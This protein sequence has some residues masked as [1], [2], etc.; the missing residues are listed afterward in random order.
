VKRRSIVLMLAISFGFLVCI[1]LGLGWLGLSR[2]SRIHSDLEDLVTKRWAKVK[3]CR[4]ALA[5]S[6]LNSRITVEVFLLDNSDQIAPLLKNRAENT[7]IISAL[8]SQ[9]QAQGV[10]PGREHELLD[11]IVLARTPYIASYLQAL[12]LLIDE[13]KYVKA[14]AVMVD[15]T[16]PLLIRYHEAWNRFVE[17]QGEQMDEAATDS[18]SH[19]A[20]AH[21]VVLSLILLAAALCGAIGFYVTLLMTKEIVRREKAE[22][23][24]GSLNTELEQKVIRRT[25][26]LSL[27]N[28]ELGGEITERKRAEADLHQAKEAAE[29]ANRAKGDFLAN[30]SHEIR[31]P[32]NGIIGMTDLALE[33]VLTQEQ[34]EFLGMVK[35]SA[36]SLLSLLNDILDFSKIEAGK[37]DFET[38]DF[39]LRD[40]LDDT[41]KALGLRAHQKR[42]ELACH[43]L[44]EVPDGLQGDPTRIRQIVVNLVGN[45]IKFTAEGEVVVKVEVQEET[46]DEVLLH[47][48]VRDT[49]GGIALEKQQTIFEAF[50]QADNSMTRK[51][52]GTGLGLAISS[53]L[54]NLMGGRIWVESDIARGSTFHFTVRLLMQKISSRKYEPIGAEGLRDL[55]VLIVDDNATNRRILQEMVLVWKMNPTLTEGGPEA[56]T[57]LE[58]ASIRG[59]PFALILLDAQ[60]P[61]MDGFSVAERIKQDARFAKSLVIMLTSAGLRG[62]AARCRELGIKAYLTK[63]IKRSDLLQAIKVVLGSRA[64]TEENFPVVTIH[65]LRESRARLSILLVEDNRVNQAVATR[66]L[67]KR[68]HLVVVV[69]SGKQAL[70]ALE[71]QTPDLILM[72]VQ[73]P[74]MDGIQATASIREGELKSGKHIPIIAMTA[75]VMAGDKERCRDAGMDGYLSKPIRAEDLF[76]TMEEVLSIPVKA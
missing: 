44:A 53:R 19:Y 30:M 25:Q 52:G 2:M 16:L 1:L 8:L 61:G 18:R 64:V 76:A 39:L 12:H 35:S 7:K 15:Q 45:A 5:Y 70:E 34:R 40:T 29:A 32:M 48:S 21:T 43:V 41:I 31:T 28:Q 63:P 14:R 10:A 72:D 69:G 58:R 9:I 71:N 42:L 67:E 66:L 49:G 57:L 74:E 75:H 68:G 27:V 37:L 6:S 56:L 47:F 36:D 26:E 59:S 65:S 11:A 60:M 17:F 33:T 23:Q 13:H 38:I 46:E 4:T 22:E 20:R 62:D 55:P 73:M 51:Y 3:L 24:V 50:T 54:V